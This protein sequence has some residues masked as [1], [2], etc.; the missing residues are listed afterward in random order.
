MSLLFA[1]DP[2][3]ISLFL[4]LLRQPPVYSHATSLPSGWPA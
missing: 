1:P 3:P 2:L 4:A